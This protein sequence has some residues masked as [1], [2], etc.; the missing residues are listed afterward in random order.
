M[1]VRVTTWIEES[2]AILDAYHAILDA[3]YDSENDFLIKI[4][5]FDEQ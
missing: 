3:F 4:G 5:V 2:H 1:Q